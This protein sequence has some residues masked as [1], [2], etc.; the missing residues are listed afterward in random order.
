MTKREVPKPPR[1]AEL[2]KL[3][4]QLAADGKISFTE[5]AI[6]ERARDRDIEIVDVLEVIRL[7]DIEGT[8]EPGKNPEEWKC[9]VVGKLHWT[10]REAGVVTPAPS[11]PLTADN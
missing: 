4:R 5:H 11:A 10:P 6:E 9:L 8:I 3:I 7:G 2:I 1:A